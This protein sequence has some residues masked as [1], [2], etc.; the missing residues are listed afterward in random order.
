MDLVFSSV[1]TQRPS[2]NDPIQFVPPSV[3]AAPPR[4]D[5]DGNLLGGH[6]A[7]ERIA[8]TF[9]GEGCGRI[10][11]SQSQLKGGGMSPV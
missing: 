7:E 9:F 10:V 11:R 3:T 8:P 6:D 5:L 2:P 1:K 4:Y